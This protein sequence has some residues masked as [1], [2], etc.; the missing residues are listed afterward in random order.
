MRRSFWV[1]QSM[2]K[3]APGGASR[4]VNI[5]KRPALELDM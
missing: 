3:T 5:A 2:L 4:R 1:M